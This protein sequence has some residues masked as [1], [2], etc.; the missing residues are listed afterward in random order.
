MFLAKDFIRNFFALFLS[1]VMMHSQKDL[2]FYYKLILRL[3]KLINY[4][5]PWPNPLV[6][7]TPIELSLKICYKKM[8]LAKDFIRN[9]FALFLSLV[10]LHSQKNLF[11]YNKLM[12]RLFKL[13]N[14]FSPWPNPLAPSS[15]IE[16]YLNCCY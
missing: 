9:L 6:P 7:S 15:P 14:F 2:F 5:S 12:L 1:L 4:F 3:F 10:I 13:I 16:L 8:F 11:F